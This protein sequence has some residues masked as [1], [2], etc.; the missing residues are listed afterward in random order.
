MLYQVLVGGKWGASSPSTPSETNRNPLSPSET[1]RSGGWL[2]NDADQRV[3]TRYREK[4]NP[5]CHLSSYG[6]LNK[7]STCGVSHPEPSPG[8]S[9]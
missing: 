2:R 4:R 3:E 5:S 7:A 9:D 6:S 8:L 1:S